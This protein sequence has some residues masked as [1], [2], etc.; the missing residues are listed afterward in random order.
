M[1]TNLAFVINTLGITILVPGG[2]VQLL[3]VVSLKRYLIPSPM[4]AINGA[5]QPFSRWLGIKFFAFIARFQVFTTQAGDLDR[6]NVL[7]LP[8]QMCFDG[9]QFNQIH[10]LSHAAA[11]L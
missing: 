8:F 6:F 11:G 4:L 5:M 10:I 2:G 3:I 1:G 9:V 7:K